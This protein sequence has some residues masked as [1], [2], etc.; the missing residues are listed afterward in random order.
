M[1]ARQGSSGPRRNSVK[2]HA[3]D[4]ADRD[5]LDRATAALD[6]PFAVVDLDAFDANAADLL[7]RAE[8]GSG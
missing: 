2:I 5:R 6:P 1:V 8:P 3:I 4:A 7:R